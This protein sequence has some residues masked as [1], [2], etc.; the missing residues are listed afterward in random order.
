[1]RPPVHGS[2]GRML[3]TVAGRH[4]RATTACMSQIGDH[5]GIGID[6]AIARR[7]WP[8][9]TALVLLRTL[10]SDPMAT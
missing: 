3:L 10:T 5:A 7:M 4:T 6:V 1:V 8:C 9:P 2:P